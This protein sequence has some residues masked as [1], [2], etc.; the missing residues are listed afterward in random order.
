VSLETEASRSLGSRLAIFVFLV[1]VNSL[2]A[3]FAVL[4]QP[5]ASGIATIYL[6]VAFMIAFALWFGMWGAIA[7]YLGCFVGAGLS[8]GVP[9]GV[10]LYWSLADVWQVLVPLVAFRELRASISLVTKRDCL[11]FFV[12]GCVLN[13]LIGAI[14]GASTLAVGGVSS[15]NGVTGMLLSWFAGNLIV[16]L[17]IT[18]LLLRYVTPHIQ[19][20]GIIVRK[21]WS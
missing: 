14:W 7:A 8:T 4:A 20:A 1:L 16:T 9:V 12:F 6:A 18:P 13:N 19:Q 11:I 10:G 2:L 15:W 5:G 21:Y 17:A 3:R